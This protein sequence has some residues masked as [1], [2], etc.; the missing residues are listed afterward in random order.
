MKNLY[1]IFIGTV[2]VSGLFF[3]V[4]TAFYNNNSLV[5]NLFIIIL[6]LGG[7][8]VTY[9]SNTLKTR[10]AIFSGASV[11]IVLIVYQISFNL[12]AFDP[13]AIVGYIMLPGFF[14]MIGG[15]S[16]KITQKQMEELVDHL[17][18]REIESES[19]DTGK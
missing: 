4:D 11:G 6:I 7:Y 10:T 17:L 15:F 14:M 19:K 9:T 3:L 13:L 5:T 16:A 1:S 12:S 2:M 18:K 8:F